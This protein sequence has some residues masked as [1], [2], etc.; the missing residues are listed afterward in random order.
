MPFIPPM[1]AARAARRGGGLSRTYLNHLE[2]GKRDP[3]FE[4]LDPPGPGARGNRGGA[5]ERLGR[6][7]LRWDLSTTEGT[8]GGQSNGRPVRESTGKAK[9][10][11]AEEWLKVQEGASA[12][13]MPL[14]PR[15]DKVLYDDAAA[16]LLLY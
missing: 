10:K 3:S 5:R 11:E 2:A 1:L 14:P 12:E 15:A 8:S 16:N 13:G 4:H 9:R 7:F 6:R